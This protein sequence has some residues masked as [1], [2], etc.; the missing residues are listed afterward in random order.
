MLGVHENKTEL[1]MKQH[2]QLRQKDRAVSC[3]HV[4]SF[5]Y[6]FARSLEEK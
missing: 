3:L 2:F 5:I 4:I 6:D 1:L